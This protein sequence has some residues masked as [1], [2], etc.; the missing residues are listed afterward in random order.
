MEN[1]LDYL[2]VL[3]A[4]AWADKKLQ[5]EELDILHG[6][7]EDFELNEDELKLVEEWKKRP[8]VWNDLMDINF[9]SFS[10]EQKKHILFLAFTIVKADGLVTGDEDKFLNDI[11]TT[12]DLES[13]SEDDLI[14][15]IKTSQKL[16]G[17]I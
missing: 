8:V 17:N 2:K 13:I 9:D 10:L 12:L 4:L 5:T 6:I 3:Y 15:E 1:I 7:K 16:Y 14:N 11:R